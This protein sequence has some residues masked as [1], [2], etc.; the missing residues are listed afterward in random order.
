MGDLLDLITASPDAVIVLGPRGEVRFVNAA[1]AALLERDAQALMGGDFGLPVLA[2]EMAELEIVRDGQPIRTVEMRVA[3]A[4]WQGEP[5]R[6]ASLR[7]ITARRQ[8]ERQAHMLGQVVQQMKDAVLLVDDQLRV[9]YVNRAFHE[10]YGYTDDEALGLPT[11]SLSGDAEEVFEAFVRQAAGVLESDGRFEAEL[12]HRRKDG[13]V[14]WGSL[15]VSPVYLGE[16]ARRFWLVIA[17]DVDERKKAE[18]ELLRMHEAERRRRE[19]AEALRQSGAA[20]SG[21]LDFEMVLDRVA[22]HLRRIIP[23]DRAGVWMLDPRGGSARAARF[24]AGASLLPSGA[25]APLQL[26]SVPALEAMTREGRP[27]AVPDAT[28]WTGLDPVHPPGSW[29]GA[30]VMAGAMPLALLTVSA[31]QPNQY[32][33]E[34]AAVLGLFAAQASMAMQN[35]RLFQRVAEMAITDEV[36]GVHT[37]RHLLELAGH[38]FARALRERRLCAIMFDI[39][40][41]KRINDTCGHAAGD[42]VLRDVAAACRASLRAGDVIGRYGGDEFVVMLPDTVAGD[43][44]LVAERLRQRVAQLAPPP[45]LGRVTVSLGVAGDDWLCPDVATLIGRADEA[46]YAAKRAGK[47]RICL[48]DG[49]QP[50]GQRS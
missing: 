4:V 49:A 45:P 38:E 42:R 29:L 31:D 33:G 22:E 41:F 40:D 28:G 13:S 18:A 1:T 12:R 7:D 50:V 44:L 19:L 48:L 46:L 21:T 47:D 16:S 6:L 30:P 11:A 3:D 32:G 5:A 17:R 15:V 14:F 27:L 23:G 39:D 43:A 37:R 20:L 34:Q 2:G 25:L 26:A 10:M 36:T 35:A 9:C 8:A 24:A